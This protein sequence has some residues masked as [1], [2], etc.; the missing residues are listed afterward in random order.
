M[1]IV[2]LDKTES[3][4]AVVLVIDIAWILEI[5]DEPMNAFCTIESIINCHVTI[6][7]MSTGTTIVVAIACTSA[8]VIEVLLW[9]MRAFVGALDPIYHCKTW[10]ISRI[11]VK[12]AVRSVPVDD[13]PINLVFDLSSTQYATKE[14]GEYRPIEYE[15]E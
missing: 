13:V 14:A 5:Y 1:V 7:K 2:V 4:A 15:I 11:H 12:D 3:G 9:F 8:S 10:P 6:K